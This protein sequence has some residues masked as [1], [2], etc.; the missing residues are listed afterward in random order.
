MKTALLYSDARFASFP[1]LICIVFF[2]YS[3]P[4]QDDHTH[5][6]VAIASKHGRSFL[7][8]PSP[9][10]FDPSFLKAAV[11]WS[12]PCPSYKIHYEQ[13]K[14]PSCLISTLGVVTATLMQSPVHPALLSFYQHSFIVPWC[15]AKH[16]VRHTL[17][18]SPKGSEALVCIDQA[19]EQGQHAEHDGPHEFF[20]HGAVS[21]TAFAGS[22]TRCTTGSIKAVAVLVDGRCDSG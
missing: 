2:Q 14:A 19:N 7:T 17:K 5:E 10:T 15:C 16:R 6:A 9:S 21:I 20:V 12:R 11:V 3:F 8:Q 13:E 4:R 18:L 22:V 1:T